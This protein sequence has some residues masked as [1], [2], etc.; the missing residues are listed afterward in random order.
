M[1][2]ETKFSDAVNPEWRE[3]WKHV[4]AAL[5]YAYQERNPRKH[6]KRF[7]YELKRLLKP[8]PQYS[9]PRVVAA[10]IDE[11]WAACPEVRPRWLQ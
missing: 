4:Q 6:L 9:D 3:F 1:A 8:Y 5:A 10:R 2:D 11:I 7:T